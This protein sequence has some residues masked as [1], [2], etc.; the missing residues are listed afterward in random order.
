VRK[1]LKSSR[2]TFIRSR[3]T[4]EDRSVVLLR[5]LM[6][7]EV[8]QWPIEIYNG[9]TE[10]LRFCTTMLPFDDYTKTRANSTSSRC[11]SIL[12][13]HTTTVK[14]LMHLQCL[15][16]ALGTNQEHEFTLSLMLCLSSSEILSLTGVWHCAV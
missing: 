13:F 16:F 9:S 7:G 11:S 14:S 10:S 6:C 4:E 5:D 3:R 1:L 15:K 12:F 2:L 8:L